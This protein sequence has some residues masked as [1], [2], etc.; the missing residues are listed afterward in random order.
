MLK[1]YAFFYLMKHDPENIRDII[2]E[3]IRYWKESRPV[4]YSGGPFNDKSGGLILFKAENM[5][6]ALELAMNDPFVV[7]D[8]IETKWLREWNRE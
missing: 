8:A 4:G 2:P 3:H 1:Q 5:E 7:R 6:T